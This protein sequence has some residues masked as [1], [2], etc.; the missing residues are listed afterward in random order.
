MNKQQL[1]ERLSLSKF[2]LRSAVEFL[3][4]PGSFNPGMATSLLQDSV[5]TFLWTLAMY[6][7]IKLDKKHSFDTLLDKVGDEFETVKHSKTSLTRLNSSRVGFK[8]Y[9]NLVV[10]SDAHIFAAN[11]E[12]FFVE[13][14]DK[15]LNLDF[16]YLSLSSAI[17]HKRT[18]NWVKKAEELHDTGDYCGSVECSAKAFAAYCSSKGIGW[19]RGDMNIQPFRDHFWN[20]NGEPLQDQEIHA[21]VEWTSENMQKLASFAWLLSMN[22]DLVAY[23]HFE[24][25]TP[26]VHLTMN[27]EFYTAWMSNRINL[28]KKDSR[29]CIDFVIDTALKIDELVETFRSE[30]SFEVVRKAKAKKDCKVRVY[31]S[32]DAEVIRIAESGEN[33]DVVTGFRIPEN[34]NFVAVL[35]DGEAAFVSSEDVELEPPSVD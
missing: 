11:V 25:T 9:G 6:G 27:K 1:M 28:T 24:K 10:S 14:C 22:L 20:L 23:R 3:Q 29:F 34:G 7:R 31:N 33:L 26:I 18:E 4:R 17:N 19:L 30:K 21:F 32:S 12:D 13:V 16:K 35:Q 5:E 8:H 15:D 2:Q